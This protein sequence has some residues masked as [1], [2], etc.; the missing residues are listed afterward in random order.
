MPYS[1]RGSSPDSPWW[2]R[3]L[4]KLVSRWFREVTDRWGWRIPA[5][6]TVAILE[7]TTARSN[8]TLP[9]GRF[10]AMDR[11]LRSQVDCECLGRTPGREFPP[12]SAVGSP[13]GPV[14]PHFGGVAKMAGA[15]WDAAGTGGSRREQRN[16]AH[17]K[18]CDVLE[19]LRNCVSVGGDWAWYAIC[20]FRVAGVPGALL[21]DRRPVA[22]SVDAT[23][24]VVFR[25]AMGEL[26]FGRSSRWWSV[27]ARGGVCR[28]RL[29]WFL[30]WFVGG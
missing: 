22:G 28:T 13:A 17:R 26:A 21:D 30:G 12:K 1:N 20:I 16:A 25:Q 18:P 4:D 23:K 8:Q 10:C 3:D 15:R 2:G 29:V 9:G 7:I 5:E 19:I 27:P 6:C 11:E 14:A 24:P